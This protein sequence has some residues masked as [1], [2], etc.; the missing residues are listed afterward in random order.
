[1]NKSEIPT[2]DDQAVRQT[3][4]SAAADVA[5]AMA[6]LIISMRDEHR[7][8]YAEVGGLGFGYIAEDRGQLAIIVD[9]QGARRLQVLLPNAAEDHPRIV[10]PFDDGGP[11]IRGMADTLRGLQQ[12][13]VTPSARLH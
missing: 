10:R 3:V 7:S 6:R 12:T 2:V 4:I 1:M 9:W 5:V 13:G 11:W 8:Y